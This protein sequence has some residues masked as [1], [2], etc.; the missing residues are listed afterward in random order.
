MVSFRGGAVTMYDGVRRTREG[1]AVSQV[2]AHASHECLEQK[3]APRLRD[4]R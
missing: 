1:S 4:I 2:P 3:P